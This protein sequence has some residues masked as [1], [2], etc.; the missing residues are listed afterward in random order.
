MPYT[1]NPPNA[2][3]C[4]SEALPQHLAHKPI[5]AFPYEQ[6]DGI[7]VGDTDV[8]YISIG[9]AQYDNESISIKAMRCPGGRWARQAEEL[10]LHRVI[11]MTLFLA[12]VLFETQNETVKIPKETFFNQ[13]SD[14]SVRKESRS[15]GELAT[16]K[17][18]LEENRQ[19][20]K[21]RFNALRNVLDGL[22]ERGIL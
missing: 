10:P 11:D 7:C 14:I 1:M 9:I 13:E 21:E 22:A 6:F 4:P 5:Y 20:L 15:Y 17:A 8:R 3:Y 18:F 16:Y 2:A 19:L 12:K